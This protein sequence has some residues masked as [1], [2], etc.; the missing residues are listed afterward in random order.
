M[1]KLLFCILFASVASAATPATTKLP[2]L[3]DDYATALQQAQQRK[4][5]IFVECWAPW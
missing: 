5:P 3:F 4:L 2:F 1:R